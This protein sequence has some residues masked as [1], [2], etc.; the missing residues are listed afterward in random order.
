MT[1]ERQRN[2]RLAK[3]RGWRILLACLIISLTGVSVRLLH[4]QDNRIPIFA[5]G[6]AEEYKANARLLLSGEVSL[7]V[8]GLQPPQDTN[9]LA[10]PPGY[11]I[12]IWLVFKLFGSSDAA[13]RGVNV[14]CD[15][16]AAVLI[17][18]IAAQF[19]SQGVAFVAGLLV[20]LSPQLAF[21]SIILLPE[22]IAVL[23]IL[24][25]VYLII[26][27]SRNPRLS[28]IALAGLCVGLSCWLRSNGLL[29]APFLTLL[30]PVLFERGSRLRYALVL[31]ATAFIVIAP[32]TI[33]N[34]IVFHR[35]VPVSLGAGVTMVEG[36]A[37]YDRE[38]K[39][40][41]PATDHGVMRMESGAH[42]RTDY[43]N[44]LFYPDGIER[45]KTRMARGLAVI[46]S[47]PGWFAGAMLKRATMMLR[48]ER[49]DIVQA[50]PAITHSLEATNEQSPVWMKSAAQWS[51][52]DI[53]AASQSKVSLAEDNQHLQIV[54]EEAGSGRP[55]LNAF[56]DV[57]QNTDYVLE[58]PVKI[59]AGSLI[60]SVTGAERN[61]LLASSNIIQPEMELTTKEQPTLLVRVPFVARNTNRARV[62]FSDG[63]A[64]SK[65]LVARIGT[66]KLYDLGAASALWTRYPRALVRTVQK[67]FLTAWMLPLALIGIILLL[68]KKAG[69]VAATLLVV[70]V[71]YLCFQSMLHTEYRYVLAVHYFLYIAVAVTLG[72]AG[73]TL[74]HTTR[75][76]IARARFNDNAGSPHAPH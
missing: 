52:N 12:L 72:L 18:F 24:C 49:V 63:K 15:V 43:L 3:A 20:A 14:A 46:R 59:E 70:P 68:L 22:S 7:F 6:M 75:K 66:V 27:A 36:I 1:R 74:W 38:K 8:R 40:G 28:T 37:D 50:E 11:P 71:Y 31:V 41:L 13:M 51:A 56:V 2:A 25:A 39:F 35:F 57:R 44:G 29:L 4:W 53:A 23:P 58:I 26:R 30:M 69:R 54:Y 33:R 62:I 17:F 60:V 64:K 16:L 45:E 67:F 73:E 10:H 42:N 61:E 47:N 48:H 55:A 32:I 65:Q 5:N 21:H 76:F 34:L 9:I 19:L